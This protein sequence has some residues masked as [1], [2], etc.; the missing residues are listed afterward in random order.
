MEPFVLYV[1]KKRR[2]SGNVCPTKRQVYA[3]KIGAANGRQFDTVQVKCTETKELI[4]EW[5]QRL[6]HLLKPN[7]NPYHE[8]PTYSYGP[9]KRELDNE[10]AL[11]TQDD[12]AN[13]YD[14]HASRISILKDF[15]MLNVAAKKG[16]TELFKKSDVLKLADDERFQTYLRNVYERNVNEPT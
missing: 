15:G 1:T 8:F 7:Y 14:L 11:L 13:I 2:K 3:L 5:P 16:R 6:S 12:I 4:F 9:I 10:N